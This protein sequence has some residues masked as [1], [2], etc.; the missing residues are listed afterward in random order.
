MAIP[1]RNAVDEYLAHDAGI[2]TRFEEPSA[3][4]H[5]DAPVRQVEDQDI[6]F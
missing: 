5:Q 4:N 6:P 3:S 1:D 2:E